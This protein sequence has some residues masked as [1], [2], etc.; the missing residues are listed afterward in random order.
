MKRKLLVIGGTTASGKTKLALSLA[1]K[2]QG[3]LI[4]CDSRQVYKGMD[5]ATGKDIPEGSPYTYINETIGGYYEFDGIPVW[6]LDLV[7]PSDEVS[8][9]SFISFANACIENIITRNALPILVGGSGFYLKALLYG[10]ETVSVPKNE[11]LRK[12]LNT[13]SPEELFR[14]LFEINPQKA[15]GM[16]ESDRKNPPRLIRAIEVAVSPQKKVAPSYTG[17]NADMFFVGL[18]SRKEYLQKKI[19][20]RVM[21]RV[22]K[23]VLDEIT[24]LRK[25]GISW[26]IQSMN[27]LGYKEWKDYFEK[28]KT[29]EEVLDEWIHDE[30]QYAKRQMTFFKKIPNITWIDTESEEYP[31]NVE[32]LV[33]EWH[34]RRT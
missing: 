9:S 21:D 17:I 10:I 15:S 13:K 2:Y 7:D 3:E 27:T 30:V 18:T 23:G 22:Q 28:R 14:M 29:K 1:R 31:E 11:Q 12:S 20:S 25:Q 6:G 34:N 24:A 16:N 19:Q 33:R 32:I 5:I 26:D 8:V 4:S